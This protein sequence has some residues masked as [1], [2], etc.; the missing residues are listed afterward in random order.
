MFVKHV[1]QIS[2]LSALAHMQK[3]CLQVHIM[4]YIGAQLIIIGDISM[5][6]KDSIPLGVGVC[7]T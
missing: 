1:R 3:L 7:S 5:N 2:M 4:M 6:F